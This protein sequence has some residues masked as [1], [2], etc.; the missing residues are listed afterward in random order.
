MHR[1]AF[2][3][4]LKEVHQMLS[5]SKQEVVQRERAKKKMMTRKKRRKKRRCHTR[6]NEWMILSDDSLYNVLLYLIL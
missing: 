2:S 6:A 1:E 5:N 3:A 4:R